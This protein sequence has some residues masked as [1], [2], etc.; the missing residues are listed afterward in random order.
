MTAQSIDEI[1]P[2]SQGQGVRP[3]PA[4]DARSPPHMIPAASSASDKTHCGLRVLA[5]VFWDEFKSMTDG[6]IMSNLVVY[7]RHLA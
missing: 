4:E 3:F 7:S 6:G 2:A 5:V 1:N